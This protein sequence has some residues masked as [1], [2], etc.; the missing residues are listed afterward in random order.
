[1]GQGYSHS[2]IDKLESMGKIKKRKLD[3]MFEQFHTKKM[4]TQSLY[5]PVFLYVVHPH[6]KCTKVS[7]RHTYERDHPAVHE[8]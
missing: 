7:N 6:A 5:S 8:F 3:T 1:M 2:L 4:G